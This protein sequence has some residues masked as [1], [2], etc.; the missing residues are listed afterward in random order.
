[1]GG[2]AL[3]VLDTHAWVWWLSRPEEISGRARETIEQ[4]MEVEAVFVSSISCW[5][6]SLLTARGRLELAIPVE[7]W[8]AR[9]EAIPWLQF[10]PLDNRI[11]LRS[12]RLPGEIHDDP[13]DRI[14]IA[15]AITLGASL[16]TRDRRIRAYPH[17][18]TIW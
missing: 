9:S 5:E 6:V 8:I 16:V 4:A 15:T 11:A 1:M 2:A 12:N 7:D 13:A 17:V 3:I 18:E 10:V 14:I